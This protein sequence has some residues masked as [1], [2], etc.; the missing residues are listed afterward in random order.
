MI[1]FPD[2]WKGGFPD[3]EKVCQ[4][5]VRP[6]T[7]LLDIYTIDP[8]SQQQVQVMNTDG[9]PRRPYLCS[10]LLD[11]YNGQL[12]VVRFYRGGGAADVGKLMDP[13]SVQIGV[14]GATRDDAVQLLEYMRQIL[15][16]FPRSGGTVKCPDGSTVSVTEVGEIDGPEIVPELDP[17]NRLV[18]HTLAVTCRLP[19]EVPDYGP[20]VT[21]IMAGA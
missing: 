3:R 7:D 19:R 14:I 10:F 6:F 9:S 15:L 4:Y 12:P 11:G 21:Q 2:W 13:A 17:D 16:A 5:A 18:V 1:V 20:F 8:N